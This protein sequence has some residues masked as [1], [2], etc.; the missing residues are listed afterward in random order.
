MHDAGEKLIM[1]KA[2]KKFKRTRAALEVYDKFVDTV[3]SVSKG[4]WGRV[5]EKNEAERMRLGRLVGRSF[6]EDTIEVNDP[7]TCAQVVTPN[8]V[9]K[10]LVNESWKGTW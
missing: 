7:E 10:F 8:S 5:F 9:R 4:D 1:A 2:S 3:W 6:G